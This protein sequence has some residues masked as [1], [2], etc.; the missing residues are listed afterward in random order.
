MAET[1]TFALNSIACQIRQQRTGETKGIT[2]F[3]DLN[4]FPYQEEILTTVI[5]AF[6]YKRSKVSNPCARLLFLAHKKEILVQAQETFRDVLKE[7]NFG[8]L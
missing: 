6:D 7:T 8:E 1:I 4:P 2:Q 5:S 3:F